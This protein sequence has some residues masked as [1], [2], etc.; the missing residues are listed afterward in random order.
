MLKLSIIIPA[1]D[2]QL[3]E[4]SLVS[5]L[6]NRPRDCEIVVVQNEGYQDPYDLAGEV[7]FVP[8]PPASSRLARIERGLAACRAPV[9]HVLACGAEV[10]EGWTEPALGH[11]RDRAVAAVAP[12]VLARDQARVASTGLAYGRGG[13]RVECRR[14]EPA[15]AIPPE[16]VPVLGPALGAAFYRRSA[17]QAL[18]NPLSEIVGDRWADVDLALRLTRAGHICLFEPRSRVVAAPNSP[19]HSSFSDGWFAERL[20]WR[21]AKEQGLARSAIGHLAV[22]TAELVRA[23]VR[24]W[25]VGRV[26]GRIAGTME[27]LAHWRQIAMERDAD[28]TCPRRETDQR[29]HR[30]N[31]VPR[32]HSPKTARRPDAS[33]VA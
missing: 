19:E 20:F 14:G 13:V 18:V 10:V 31:A 8:V 22:V 1:D 5:I 9:V 30:Q 28:G 24:P 7:A 33:P 4:T 27:W 3:M 17:L 25:E 29:A 16:A 23:A 2:Q 26:I 32:D 15:A 21:H 11:F 6:Q 12:L